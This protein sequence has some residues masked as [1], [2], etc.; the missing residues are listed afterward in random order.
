MTRL[1][2]VDDLLSVLSR[3][4]R[5]RERLA[6]TKFKTPE[7]IV[8]TAAFSCLFTL[9]EKPMRSGELAEHLYA[10]P[11]TVSRHIASLV[12]LGYVRREADPRDGRATILVLTESGRTQVEAVRRH[13]MNAVDVM[14]EDFTTEEIAQL[15]GLMGRVVDA[16]DKLAASAYSPVKT[17]GGPDDA[18]AGIDGDASG[19]GS[20][21]DDLADATSDD[22]TADTS[23]HTTAH[24]REKASR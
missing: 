2:H 19:V 24:T 11:S 4:G 3:Y 13:R 22:L 7:G 9:A 8:E 6:V 12:R 17:L 18:V 20:R 16:A 15:S 14:L 10:D 21:D 1:H 5:I 23:A